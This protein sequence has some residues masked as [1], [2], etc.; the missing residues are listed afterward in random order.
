[1]P[2]RDTIL[3]AILAL[4]A[5]WISIRL[6]RLPDY[7]DAYYHFNAA[8][9]LANGQGLTD[10]YLWTYLG[11][12]PELPESGVFP[13]HLYWMPLT[14]IITAA[15]LWLSGGAADTA[16][17]LFMPLLAGMYGLAFW[18][19]GKL[20][21]SRRHAWAA[22]LLAI[23]NGFFIRFW[24]A[25]DTFTPYAFLGGAC[26]ALMGVAHGRGRLWL[27]AAAGIF[28]GLGHLTRADG[29]LLVLVGA[30]LLIFDGLRRSAA[31]RDV[32]RSLSLLIGA[33]LL[34]MLPWFVRNL[35]LVGTPLPVGGTQAV[36]FT[37]Y[38]DLFNFPP[39]ASPSDLLANGAGL[40]I[41]TRW[42]A[43]VNNLGTFIAVEG[44]V[45]G[46]PF[47]LFGLWLLRRRRFLA[48]LTVYA[49]GLHAAMTL[50]FPFPGY[51]GGLFHSAA[52]LIPFW[53]ALAVIGV[54]GA[55]AAVAR[56]RRHWNVV[57]AR[58]VFTA[59]L[60]GIAVALTLFVGA[61]GGSGG[62]S[63]RPPL[64]DELLRH[65]P[66]DAR[67]LINDPAQL[68]YHTGLGGTV[69]PNAQ[70]DVIPELAQRYRLTHVLIEY[71]SAGRPVTTTPLLSLAD[72]P[73]DF[74]NPIPIDYPL[75]RLY[76]I[77]IPVNPP[78]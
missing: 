26:L 75:A 53:A 28:A 18:L 27:W 31:W 3:F 41:A 49:L 72:D 24:G 4:A 54:D 8:A 46:A 40:L 23:F 77:E 67:L 19:G 15:G 10:V 62:E 22:G 20:G 5:A 11:A 35:M 66:P 37:E 76:A 21:D 2:R 59:G 61:R 13:S 45:I 58:R 36:W 51:R 69:L 48:P 74:L 70:A 64:Y 32:L 12:P 14:S 39:G 30:G 52:A 33:Y 1:M 65:L 63:A 29:L 17:L 47:M 68:Y 16:A 42:E 9:R 50:V 60:I 57:A 56:R 55:V 73:P 7:T 43:L 71:D 78:D 25:V 34:T 44:W 6:V 38:N